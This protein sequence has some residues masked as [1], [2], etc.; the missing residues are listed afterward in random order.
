MIFVIPTSLLNNC[1][2]LKNSGRLN[3]GRPLNSPHFMLLLS[4]VNANSKIIYLIRKVSILNDYINLGVSASPGQDCFYLY[5]PLPSP[6]KWS[7]LRNSS[8]STE[9]TSIV[10]V[11]NIVTTCEGYCCVIKSPR[12]PQANYVLVLVQKITHSCNLL[13]NL[14]DW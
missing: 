1:K 4:R 5:F 6:H 7:S 11:L 10:K 3:N 9:T 2:L 14:L 8:S 13:V 12:V